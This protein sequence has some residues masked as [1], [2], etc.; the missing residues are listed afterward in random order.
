MEEQVAGEKKQN[1]WEKIKHYYLY[2]YK[3]LFIIPAVLVI[4]A[5]LQIIFQ[6]AS[7]GDFMIKGVSLKGGISVTVPLQA[8]MDINA[9]GERLAGQFPQYDLSIRALSSRGHVVGFS[10]DADIEGTDDAKINEFVD[11]IRKQTGLALKKGEFTLEAIGSSLGSSF[12]R[13]VFKSLL[14]A[15]LFMSIV[16]ILYYRN[17]V[18]AFNV[19]FC[20]FADILV[21]LAVVN[22]IGIKINTGGLAAFLMLIGYSVDTD[23]LLSTRMLKRKDMSMDDRIFSSVK[24]GFFMTATTLLVVIPALIF[25]QSEVIKQ[26]MLIL[27]IGLFA[28]MVFTWLQN[29]G[30]LRLY[31][32][33]KQK[34]QHGL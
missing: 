24:T 29:M 22:L 12:F 4:L 21:T 1:L 20:V 2:H 8:A 25:S 10:L 26:I 30:L 27:L 15:F 31:I 6:I 18:A 19:I 16:V 34:V 23:M 9:L 32:E 28:D 17:L 11:A 3:K 7:T 33:R 5:I 14:Y 13:E